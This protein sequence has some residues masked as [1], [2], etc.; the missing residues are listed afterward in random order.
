MQGGGFPTA[1]SSLQQC[2]QYLAAGDLQNVSLAASRAMRPIN[3]MERAHWTNS[4]K[5][6]LSPVSSPLAVTYHHVA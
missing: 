2:D 5:G 4:I 1:N 6:L 3:L